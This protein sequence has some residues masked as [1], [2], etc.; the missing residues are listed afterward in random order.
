MSPSE[1]G[2][3]VGECTESEGYLCLRPAGPWQHV[4]CVAQDSAGPEQDGTSVN[5]S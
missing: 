1:A 4:G 2:C 5:V 3:T